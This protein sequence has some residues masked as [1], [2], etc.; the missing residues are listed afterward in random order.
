LRNDNN[1]KS[2]LLLSEEEEKKAF[3][4]LKACI[5][6][7]NKQRPKVVI[8]PAQQTMLPKVWK[9]LARIR[10]SIPVL[11]TDGSVHYKFWLNGFQGIL[12][13]RSEL[14]DPN[15]TQNVWLHEQMEQSRMAK[16][17]LFCF[18]DCDP[19]DLPP[20][21]LKQLARGRVLCLM[22]LVG[23]SSSGEDVMLD[24]S[25]GGMCSILF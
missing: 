5:A 3:K 25:P 2:L 15:S 12:L 7:I 18:C 8:V 6:A 14:Q 4:G 21:V 19:R 22:G 13:Q 11:W 17:Q 10:D 16:P 23:P 24:Y 9:L 20:M 1:S